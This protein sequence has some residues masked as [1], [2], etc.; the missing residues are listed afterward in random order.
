MAMKSE[1]FKEL[2]KVKVKLSLC[3]FWLSTTPWRRI[4]EWRYSS[5]HYLT[6]ALDGGEWSASHPGR[7]TLT[8]RIPRTH[9]I[10][11]W[12]GHSRSGRDGEEK[13]SQPLLGLE[14]LMIQSVVQR[15]T[16]ELSGCKKI[17]T[18]DIKFVNRT[19]EYTLLHEDILEGLNVGPV[20]NKVTQC[21]ED[22]RHEKV[23]LSLCLT[24]HHAL[25]T[26]WGLE[27]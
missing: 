23:K 19:T 17:A 2:I 15:C 4:G 26:Y 12:V 24:K 18:I 25:K 27:V 3:F 8:E 1:H 13:N 11:D 6:S 10:G 5:A 22:G 21:K 9:W 14:P 20:E 7:F 16:T